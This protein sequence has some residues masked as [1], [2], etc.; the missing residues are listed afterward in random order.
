MSSPQ[1]RPTR[2]SCARVCGRTCSHP[3]SRSH[4]SWVGTRDRP[5]SRRWRAT[6]GSCEARAAVVAELLGAV[7]SA[8]VH[9][10]AE[11]EQLFSAWLEGLDA[12]AAGRAAVW[13][14][15]DVHWASPDLLAFLELAGASTRSAGRLVV[16]SAR[17]TLLDDRPEWVKDGERVDLPSPSAARDRA[18][19]ARARR[20]RVAAG[21][22]SSASPS[23]RP[24]IRSSSRSCCGRGP[25][26]GS[27][28][29]S[30]T[31]A[32]GWPHPPTTW[33]CR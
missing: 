9:P 20:R 8:E 1:R 33:S 28:S 29:P 22:S 23:G 6:A 5:S 18:A 17:P 30:R 16:A 31:P 12:I 15:E 19:R 4:S 2:R 26:S 7:G 21:S 11:R 3:S 24:A 10:A 32:G 13:L 14:V 27:L 25:A